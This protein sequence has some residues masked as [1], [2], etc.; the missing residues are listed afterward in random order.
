[1]IINVTIKVFF[2][3]KMFVKIVQVQGTSLLHKFKKS[4]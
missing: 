3:T 1:M 4:S 2:Q